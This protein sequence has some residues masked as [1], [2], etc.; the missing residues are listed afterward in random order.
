[1]NAQPKA[2]NPS[3]TSPLIGDNSTGDQK[4]RKRWSLLPDISKESR[5]VLIQLCILFAFDN[6]A[7]GLAPV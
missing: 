1:M 6:F 4:K 2:A 5:V 3:E 7:S